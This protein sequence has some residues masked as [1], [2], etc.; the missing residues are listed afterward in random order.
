MSESLYNVALVHNDGNVG[1][2]GDY[3]GK[4]LLVVNVASLCGFT[5]QYEDLVRLHGKYR[6]SGLEILAFPSSDFLDQEPGSDADI[7]AL[8]GIFE[9]RFPGLQEDEG[10]RI[11]PA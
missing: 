1:S 8:C 7:A 2:L 9:V 10:D 5:P 3:R 4:V 6:D 11:R